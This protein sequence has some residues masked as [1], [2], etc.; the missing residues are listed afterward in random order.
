MQSKFH[1]NI[2]QNGKWQCCGRN[3]KQDQGCKETD[4]LGYNSPQNYDK[5][6]P[7]IPGKFC[8]CMK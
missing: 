3:N 2:Y 8:I 7:D 5:P 4:E 6:L 1:P